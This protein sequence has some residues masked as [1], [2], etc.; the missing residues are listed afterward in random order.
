MIFKGSGFYL[1]DYTKYGK[2]TEK[3]LA[4]INSIKKAI[5]KSSKKAEI[6]LSGKVE[7]F[8]NTEGVMLVDCATAA[9]KGLL[10]EMRNVAAS[11]AK[12]DVVV[13]VDDDFLFPDTWLTR[14]EDYSKTHGWKIL[15]NKILFIT[16]SFHK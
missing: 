5:E 10:G 15:G 1:T 2:K 4:E 3:T 6:I 14:L 16:V 12:G 13:F 8:E 9:E 11:H 7:S